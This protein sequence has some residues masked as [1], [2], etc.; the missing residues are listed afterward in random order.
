MRAQQA[1]EIRSARIV[2]ATTA[3]TVWSCDL[4]VKLLVPTRDY[5]YHQRDTHDVVAVFAIAAALAYL[6]PRVGSAAIGLSSGLMVGAALGN[7]SSSIIFAQGVPNPFLVSSGGY[8]I[9]FNLADVCVLASALLSIVIVV[10]RIVAAAVEQHRPLERRS[11][12]TGFVWSGHERRTRPRRAFE[13]SFPQA[14]WP[15]E[16]VPIRI[17]VENPDERRRGD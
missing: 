17:P 8:V 9:A 1:A 5:A 2:L 15:P 4:I 10:P 7:A 16:A 13:H 12:Q 3:A 6:A 11:S 14:G